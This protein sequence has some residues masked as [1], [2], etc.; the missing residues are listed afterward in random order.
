MGKL[1]KS[2][3][4]RIRCQFQ[5]TS[6]TALIDTGAEINALDN[7]FVNSLQIGIIS[8]TEAAKAANQLPLDVYSQTATPIT[9]E[10]STDLG[11][12]S[13]HLG[14]VL[15]IAN[16]GTCCLIGEP[17]KKKNNIVCLPR[18]KIIIF[19]TGDKVQYAPYIEDLP[20]YSLLRAVQYKTL[21]PGDSFTYK[22]PEQLKYENF[23]SLIPR[24]SSTS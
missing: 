10:C 19:A 7:D 3:S 17:A 8:T 2:R 22:L 15:V 18:Q 1:D 16:L 13:V 9:I 6:F 21:Q 4:S 12:V 11:M 14:I 23:V 20:R 24:P 5:G